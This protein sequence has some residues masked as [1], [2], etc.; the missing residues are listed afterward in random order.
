MHGSEKGLQ[1]S[2]RGP[3]LRKMPLTA[4]FGRSLDEGATMKSQRIPKS[5]PKLTICSRSNDLMYD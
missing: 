1:G 4:G 3:N 2:M 5:I